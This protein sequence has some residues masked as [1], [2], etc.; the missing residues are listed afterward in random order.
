MMCVL[1]PGVGGRPCGGGT[2][3]EMKTATSTAFH[4]VSRLIL[5]L[6]FSYSTMG[7][8]CD[9]GRFFL[10]RL[11]DFGLSLK[12]VLEVTPV[13]ASAGNP[14]LVSPHFDLFSHRH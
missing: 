5:V 1:S 13:T 2:Q 3:A 14:N 8:H 9:L 10:A 11:E 12:P 4:V 6:S 7:Y